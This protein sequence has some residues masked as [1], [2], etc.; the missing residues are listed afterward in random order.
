MSQ[1]PSLV[2]FSTLLTF[3]CSGGFDVPPA[4]CPPDRGSSDC[5]TGSP[6]SVFSVSP[7]SNSSNHSTP[8]SSPDLGFASATSSISIN[9]KNSSNN[10][11]SSSSRPK[12][13]PLTPT[14]SYS[15]VSSSFALPP[16]VASAPRQIPSSNGIYNNKSANHTLAH[17]LATP[18]LTPSDSPPT[19]SSSGRNVGMPG[20]PGAGSVAGLSHG[21]SHD[22][23][24]LDF[25]AT[26]FPK[27][28]LSALPYARSVHIQSAKMVGAF[29]GV[30]LDLPGRGKT[31]YVDGKGAA[32]I[33]LRD[34]CGAFILVFPLHNLLII[35]VL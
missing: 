32:N 28:A 6:A 35:S 33:R 3:C 18:P 12:A 16:T 27:S 23:A 19:T 9:R 7:I 8:Q 15:S 21:T 34:R 1:L 30:V 5:V 13:Y 22:R 4:K 31:L 17:G 14:H 2:D 20:A 29:S 25:L 11:S 10:N 24:A 26:L